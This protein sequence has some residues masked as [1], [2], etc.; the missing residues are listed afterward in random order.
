MHPWTAKIGVHV[1]QIFTVVSVAWES[2][3]GGAALVVELE[4]ALK[5]WRRTPEK[6]SAPAHEEGAHSGSFSRRLPAACPTTVAFP[7]PGLGARAITCR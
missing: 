1:P 6:F 5:L 7:S 4:Q 2:Q 3:R